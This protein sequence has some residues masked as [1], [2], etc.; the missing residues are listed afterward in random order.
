MRDITTMKTFITTTDSFIIKKNNIIFYTLFENDIFIDQYPY[1]NIPRRYVKYAKLLHRYQVRGKYLYNKENI[2]KLKTNYKLLP[3]DP[4]SSNNYYYDLTD[5]IDLVGKFIQ[6][7]YRGT[8]QVDMYKQIFADIIPNSNSKERYLIYGVNIDKSFESNIFLRKIYPILRML[9]QYIDGKSDYFPFDEIFLLVYSP[10][11]STNTYVKIFD[12]EDKTYNY[13]RTFSML[14]KITPI[15]LDKEV[16]KEEILKDIMEFIETNR[17]DFGINTKEEFDKYKDKLETVIS[18]FIDKESDKNISFIYNGIKNNTFNKQE[19]QKWVNLQIDSVKTQDPPTKVLKKLDQ[20]EKQQE[21]SKQQEAPQEKQKVQSF[22]PNTKQSDKQQTLTPKEL[23]TQA[24]KQ[25]ETTLQKT[26]IQKNIQPQKKLHVPPPQKKI[27]LNKL[28]YVLPDRK[29]EDKQVNHS[30]QQKTVNVNK[31]IIAKNNQTKILDFQKEQYK[32]FPEQI[33]LVFKDLEKGNYPLKLKTFELQPIKS[34]QKDIYESSLDNLKIILEDDQ[35]KLTTMNLKVPKVTDDGYFYLDGNKRKLVSQFIPFPIYIYKPH[36]CRIQTSYSTINIIQRMTTQNKYFITYIAGKRMPLILMFISYLGFDKCLKFFDI[37]LKTS[38][39]YNLKYNNNL[40]KSPTGIYQIK[41]NNIIYQFEYKTSDS[42]KYYLLNGFSRINFNNPNYQF[43]YNQYNSNKTWNDILSYYTQDA[44]TKFKIKKVLDYIIDNLSSR[45]LKSRDWPTDICDIIKKVL[46]ILITKEY[47]EQ[48]DLKYYRIRNYEA[49]SSIIRSNIMKQYQIYEN[50]KRAG[51]KQTFSLDPNIIIKSL[52]TAQLSQSI[53]YI[54]PIE[55][56][57]FIDKVTFKG[58]GS[59]LTKESIENNDSFRHLHDSYYKIVDPLD[60]PEGGAI[61]ITQHL[62]TNTNILDSVGLLNVSKIS[63]DNDNIFGLTLSTVPFS[64]KSEPT[65]MI[66]ASAHQKQQ[67]P[68]PN[69]DRPL[70]QTGYEELIPNLLSDDFIIKT[71]FDKGIVKEVT[72]KYIVIKDVKTGQEEKFDISPKKLKGGQTLNVVSRFNVNVKPGNIVTKHDIIQNFQGIKNG[73]LAQGVNLWTQ[74]MMWKG[75][76][77]E[78]GIVISDAIQDKFKVEQFKEKLLVLDKG[79]KLINI[80][81]VK[82]SLK[83]SDI[84]IQYKPQKIY[85]IQELNEED[86]A[87]VNGLYELYQIEPG[88][89][90]KIEVYGDINQFENVSQLK[91]YYNSS[92]KYLKGESLKDKLVIQINYSEVRGIHVGDKLAN[93]H[94]NKGVV[95]YIEKEEN[96]PITPWGDKI[97]LILNPL[98]VIGRTNTGQIF[99]LY[100]NLIQEFVRRRLKELHTNREKIQLIENVYLQLDNTPGQKLYLNVKQGLKRM[101]NN[102]LNDY[103]DDIIK[104]G[105]IIYQPPFNTTNQDQIIKQLNQLKLDTKYKLYLPEYKRYT[106]KPIQ[107]GLMYEMRLEHIASLKVG[108]TGKQAKDPKTGQQVKRPGDK[109][110]RLSEQD[111]YSLLQYDQKKVLGELLNS[112]DI[113]QTNKMYNNI[114]SNGRTKLQISDQNK[115]R[116]YLD[117]YLI[118]MGVNSSKTN[119]SEII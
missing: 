64:N 22:K 46:P 21:L 65:R 114:L 115:S 107:I 78:D 28:N 74:Y 30:I 63:K 7:N 52:K 23:E 16:K 113:K 34:Q 79:D 117:Q 86:E 109:Q 31:N 81:H 71:K 99:E 59:G 112:D 62:T 119:V 60:T 27:I 87:I 35:K 48:N 13:Y 20:E 50:Q 90:L 72:D 40:N 103:F 70:T 15:E 118:Q 105:F 42:Y 96:M 66:M 88:E 85:E 19:L 24:E 43:D 18:A 97:Q 25:K 9:R 95:T 61:G 55:Y 94:G 47:F 3:Q 102:Q 111:T 58:E 57:S 100:T 2:K 82:T 44:S 10:K 83:P 29:Y 51:L 39:T 56:V 38:R 53:E 33:R 106:E 6:N 108:Q 76:T 45:I 80:K 5:Q 8:R 14:K 89:I 37:H 54:N 32:G 116:D 101:N 77:Y 93:R 67:V 75:Y 41:S 69:Q 1:L 17:K 73:T 92:K 49:I 68:L 98:G 26:F 91:R 4:T 11:L 36:Y 84:I 104:N 110:Q 12:K